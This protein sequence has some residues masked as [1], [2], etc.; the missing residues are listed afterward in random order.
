MRLKDARNA[1]K[2][3][4]GGM[5]AAAGLVTVYMLVAV[6]VGAFGSAIS[7][8]VYVLEPIVGAMLVLMAL[9]ILT[10]ISLGKFVYYVQWPVRKGLAFSRIVVGRLVRRGPVG[11]VDAPVGAIE[12]AAQEG[13]YVGLFTYGV[14]YAAASA[15][16][17]APVIIALIV[18]A[19]A[20]AT[21]LGAVVIFLVFAVTAAAL[22]VVITMA[23]G[24]YGGKISRKWT[25][26]P[27]M[28]KYASSL[29]LLGVGLYIITYY[30]I[31]LA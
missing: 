15:G 19:A 26:S 11:Q 20:Q 16:C 17:M 28:V 9:I 14:G 29:L 4:K 18:L 1:R 31:G 24:L 25:P 12:Q 8:H 27:A 21:F 22:M 7:K 30:F 23:V 6:L 13:G 10:E 2:A 3:L 5:A